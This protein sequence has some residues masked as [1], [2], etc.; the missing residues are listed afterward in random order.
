MRRYFVF[1]ALSLLALANLASGQTGNLKLILEG[2]FLVCENNGTH[3]LTILMPNLQG[4]HYPAGFTDGAD[5]PILITGSGVNSGQYPDYTDNVQSTLGLQWADST[6]T[7]GAMGR[8]P[9]TLPK[10]TSGS[11]AFLYR[12]H[13]YCGNLSADLQSFQLTVPAPDQI[14]VQNPTKELVFVIKH[15]DPGGTNRWYGGECSSKKDNGCQYATR[16]ILFY[17]NVLLNTINMTTSCNGTCYVTSKWT[18]NPAAD[19]GSEIEI[20]L[21]AVPIPSSDDHVHVQNAFWAASRLSKDYQRELHYQGEVQGAVMKGEIQ[22]GAETQGDDQQGV[23]TKKE[24]H[25]K[26]PLVPAKPTKHIPFDIPHHEVCQVVPLF[27][28]TNGTACN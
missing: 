27:V 17:S 9:S 18:P 7:Y 2:P 23:A 13:G 21:S 5:E 6:H 4:T 22:Q 8:V 19:M 14:W 3:S 24:E 28:C 26:H 20:T 11:G 16:L 25:A 1:C 10:A 12:E 15:P